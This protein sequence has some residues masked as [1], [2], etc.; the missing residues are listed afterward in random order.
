MDIV[1]LSR[2]RPD[3]RARWEGVTGRAGERPKNKDRPKAA[4]AYGV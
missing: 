1:V 4:F 3:V 2:Q